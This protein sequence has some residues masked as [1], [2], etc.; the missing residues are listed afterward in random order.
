MAGM[1]TGRQSWDMGQAGALHGGDS[2]GGQA[3]GSWAEEEGPSSGVR[4]VFLAYQEAA[5]DLGRAREEN[6]RL[7]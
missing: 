7:R 5:A 3:R 6:A 2:E 1:G 4:E